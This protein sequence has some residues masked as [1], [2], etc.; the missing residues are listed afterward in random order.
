ME[1]PEHAASLHLTHNNHKA[2]HLTVAQAISQDDFGY[3]IDDWV[4][5]GQKQKAIATNECWTLQWYPQTPIGFNL[6]SAADLHVL[7]EAANVK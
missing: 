3:R 2:A 6:M 1:F 4:S 7:L 5:E